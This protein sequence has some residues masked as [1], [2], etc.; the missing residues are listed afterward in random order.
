[1]NMN[2]NI[3]ED[4]S[5][6]NDFLT[7]FDSIK[8]RPNRF[9]LHDR[10]SGKEFSDIIESFYSSELEKNILTE[11]IPSDDNYII[12][13]KVFLKIAENIWISYVIV[14]KQLEDF[15]INEVCFY[16]KNILQKDDIEE[17]VNK[18][19]E[20]IVDYEDNINKLN[21]LSINNN[22]IDLEPLLMEEE[23]DIENMYSDSVSKNI[24]KLIKN[25]KKEKKGL[26]ILTGERGLGKTNICKYIV[27]K[28]DRIS[29]FIPNNMIE[30]TINSPDFKNFLSKFD[31]ALIIIDDCEFLYNPVYGK[32]SYFSNNILQLVDGLMSDHLNIHFL[33]VF[34]T[35][36]DELDDSLIECNSLID[37]INF[38]LLTSDMATELSKSLGI[39]KKYKNNTRLID[40]INSKKKKSFKG[41]IG[42]K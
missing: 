36:E 20:C 4:D 39:N 13:E 33:L 23:F 35:D 6:L 34:N 40:V 41:E 14:N 12:N 37:I 11:Y 24:E 7:I 1:M 22:I 2:I 8:S 5:S 28:T 17:M 32:L 42:L 16:Y 30:Q 31:K 10:F 9:I 19:T 21:T 38:E 29:I 27:S 25:I 18:I 3:N 26:S 15:I